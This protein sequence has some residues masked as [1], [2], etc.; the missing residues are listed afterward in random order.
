MEKAVFPF[1]N[2]PVWAN[3]LQSAYVGSVQVNAGL[4]CMS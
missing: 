1:P 4:F 3:I 2:A